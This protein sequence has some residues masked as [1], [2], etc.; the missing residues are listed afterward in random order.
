MRTLKDV[1][2]YSYENVHSES[3]EPGVVPAF[4]IW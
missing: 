4:E 3:D 2:Q 1:V